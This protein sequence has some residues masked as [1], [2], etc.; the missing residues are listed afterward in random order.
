MT[1]KKVEEHKKR[2]QERHQKEEKELRKHE[3]LRVHLILNLTIRNWMKELK[4]NTNKNTDM[5]R[6]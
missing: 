5:L 4:S 3:L 6:L 1:K 2:I